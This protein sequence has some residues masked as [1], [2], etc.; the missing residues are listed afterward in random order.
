VKMGG[1]PG[2]Q[3]LT[4]PDGGELRFASFAE[5]GEQW[6]RFAA[7]IPDATLYHSRPWVELL[8]AAHG[9][10]ILVATLEYGS[11][12]VAGCL[13]AR[14]TRPFARRLI[15]LPDSEHCG[16]LAK[17]GEA[18]DAFLSALASH[19]RA[20]GGFEI[21][22]AAAPPAPWETVD[23]FAQWTVEMERPAEKLHRALDRDVRRNMRHAVEA[24]ITVERGHSLEYL[25]RFYRL[26][27]DTRRRLGVPPR[28]FRYFKLLHQIFSR[29]DALSVW[30]ARLHDT[31]LAGLVML[32]D[33]DV[34]Y[35]KM[36]ARSMDCPNGANHL[37]FVSA[38]DEF[39][40][41]VHR[42]DLGRVDIRNRGLRDFKKRL[43][44]TSTPLP[45]AY[46]PRAPRNISS[47]VLSG[48]TQ[49]LSQAWR[50]LPL[51]TTRVLGTVVYGFLV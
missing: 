10:N 17:D 28:P 21:H 4:T 39:A 33:G 2:L 32:Q 36:N 24:G 27:L 41:R 48:P 3:T 19:P 30:I 44:A 14:P 49:I 40:G 18:R 42:W 15:S 11:E 43:G 5:H 29:A 9:I 6:I 16:P 7:Q 20:R 47:E 23:T 22:G 8:R 37:M 51:W 25:R 1:T 12:P 34:L 26:H 38:M 13:F 31:D 46:F 45:Y 50:R 35:A